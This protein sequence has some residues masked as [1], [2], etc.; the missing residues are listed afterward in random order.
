MTTPTIGMNV[1]EVDYK[2]IKFLMWDLGGQELLRSK[3]YTYYMNTHVRR[4][5]NVH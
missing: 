2:N 3:W 1:E 4:K 5:S